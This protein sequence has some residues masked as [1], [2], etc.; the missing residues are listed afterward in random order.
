MPKSQ[1]EFVQNFPIGDP[2]THRGD[3]GTAKSILGGTLR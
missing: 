1:I 3:G 2:S